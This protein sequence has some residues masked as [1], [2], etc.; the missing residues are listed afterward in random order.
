MMRVKLP[1]VLLG[2]LL[3]FVAALTAALFYFRRAAAGDVL[4]SLQ[5][6]AV[7]AAALG[8]KPCRNLHS[9]KR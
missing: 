6:A 4:Y 9:V 3:A 7:G 5:L 2:L 8:L 1:Y